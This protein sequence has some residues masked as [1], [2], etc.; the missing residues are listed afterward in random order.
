MVEDGFIT[1]KDM[2][3]ALAQQLNY[4]TAREKAQKAP[5]FAEMVL[6]ELREK[7]SEQEIARSGYQVQTTLDGSWQDQAEEIISSQVA[8]LSYANVSNAAMVAIEPGTGKVR[9]VVGSAD[10][11][12]EKF[13]KVNMANTKRQPGSSF[14]PIYYAKALEQGLVT[15]AT[16]L[17]D[18]PTTF[19]NYSP[20]NYD[21]SYR[22]DISVRR[23]LAN[24]LNIPSVELL[25]KFGI[26]DAIKGAKQ[27][28]I[29]S[30]DENGQ[31]GLSL[32]LGTAEVT[33]WDM[34]NAYATFAAQGQYNEP[35][36]IET[37]TDKY[38]K[39]IYKYSPAPTSRISPQAAFLISSI[40]SDNSARS[41]L[42]GSS[43]NI[44]RTAAVK[45]GTTENYRDAW[46]IGYTPELAVG[47]WVGNN[48]ATEIKKL[49]GST[50]AAPIWKKAIQTFLN[51]R[52]KSEFTVPTG[53][54]RISI[55]YGTERKA[56]GDSNAF[57][58]YFLTST[59]PTATCST[60]KDPEPV[61][62][63]TTS[64]IPGTTTTT[65]DTPPTPIQ[66]NP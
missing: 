63:T 57:M 39:V 12:N 17:H 23:S 38:D 62:T 11:N 32:A 45:T 47:V 58:E 66:T 52:P 28:G 22:G 26:N 2:D 55:C 29:K 37:I 46:T 9:V 15:P 3:E 20:K 54:E 4:N 43:L 42:F 34:T 56:I 1:Q 31:Y 10:W 51:G 5:H 13:G 16:I 44:N 24:S 48:D 36:T 41:M 53:V 59:V 25:E 40:L 35:T 27:L 33:L 18:T 61:T 21:K 19:G 60:Q 64:T 7:Y 30:L 8:N 65:I 14:K 50:A 6:K 49:G